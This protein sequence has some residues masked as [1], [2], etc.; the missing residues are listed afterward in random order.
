MQALSDAISKAIAQADNDPVRAAY[1]RVFE[2]C[3]GLSIAKSRD[4]GDSDPTKKSYMPFGDASYMTML[5]TKTQR[6]V[7][8]IQNA[9]RGDKP[10]FEGIDDSLK[11]LINYAFFYAVYRGIGQEARS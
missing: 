3:L 8:L 6:L 7:S 10:N 9:Q 11:D 4:Y 1:L 2:E 5:H